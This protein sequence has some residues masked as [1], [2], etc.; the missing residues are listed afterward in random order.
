VTNQI[1]TSRWSATT[2]SDACHQC[3][4]LDVTLKGIKEAV[5]VAEFD[6]DEDR[7]ETLY[8]YQTAKQ[9]IQA[10]KC[11]QLR[12]VRQD[13]ARV[14]VLKE[15]NEESVLIISDGA[16]N[17]SLRCTVNPNKTGSRKEGFKFCS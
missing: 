1:K 5:H 9:A 17:L 6:S 12:S 8:L 14:D 2:H 11:H 3:E 10:W 4:A 15:L 7:E 16:M 13:Q